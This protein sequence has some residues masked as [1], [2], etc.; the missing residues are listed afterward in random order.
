MAA[1]RAA[2]APDSVLAAIYASAAATMLTPSLLVFSVLQPPLRGVP[3][4]IVF[5]LFSP[6]RLPT[7]LIGLWFVCFARRSRSGRPIATAHLRTGEWIATVL[8][9]L[10]LVL[11]V[12]STRDLQGRHAPPW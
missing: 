9:A 8:G 12:D 4:V 2:A 5:D 7:L 6:L 10:T 1:E 11:G 3:Y